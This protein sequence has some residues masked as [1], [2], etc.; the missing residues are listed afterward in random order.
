M[1]AT[2]LKRRASPTT[3]ARKLIQLMDRAGVA[4]ILTPASCRVKPR[5]GITGMARQDRIDLHH[6]R[7]LEEL[8]CARR[9]S[10]PEAA[11]AHLALS[12]LHLDRVRSLSGTR[13]PAPVLELVCC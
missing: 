11:I 12:E 5:V 8:E 7:A 10:C 2:G 13:R 3:K 6:G 4:V 1:T 9:A